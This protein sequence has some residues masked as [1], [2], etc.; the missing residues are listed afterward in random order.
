MIKY[1]ILILVF[2]TIYSI[3]FLIVYFFKIKKFKIWYTFLIGWFIWFIF[4]IIFNKYFFNDI[5][6]ANMESSNYQDVLFT[7]STGFIIEPIHHLL[8]I[9]SLLIILYRIIIQK[10][11]KRND[12]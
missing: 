11:L 2:T 7:I 9:I 3:S 1:E 6:I 10:K 4:N 12:T 8:A 5:D